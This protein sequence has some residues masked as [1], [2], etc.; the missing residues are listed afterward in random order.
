MADLLKRV[1]ME[2]VFLTEAFNKGLAD[3]TNGLKKSEDATKKTTDGIETISEASGGKLQTALSI[4]GK[5]FGVFAS[6]ALAAIGIVTGAIT[7]LIT[8][9]AALGLK[10]AAVENIETAFTA[11][12]GTAQVSL[13][14]LRTAVSGTI[15][16]DDLM[17]MAN[18]ALIG[19]SK[20]LAVAMGKN[21]PDALKIAGAASKAT[22][23]DLEDVFN[24]IELAIKRGS[25]RGLAQLGILVDQKATY[26][27]Y[28]K[29]IGVAADALTQ[30]QKSTA[31]MNAIMAAGQPLLDLY[32]GKQRSLGSYMKE[33]KANFENIADTIGSWF[34]PALKTVW[35]AITK[36]SGAFLEAVSAGGVLEP[37][38]TNLGAVMSFMADGFA[39]GVDLIMK[40]VGELTGKFKSN[41]DNLGNNALQWGIN[42]IVQLAKGIIQGATGALNAAAGFV[43]KLLTNWF[44]PGS[45]PKVAPQMDTWGADTMNVWL[46]GF[47]DAD[48]GLLN[49]LQGPIRSAMDLLASDPNLVGPAWANVSK[50][51]AEAIAGGDISQAF[52]DIAA[53]TGQYS[54]QIIKLAQDELKLKQ[55][56]DAMTASEER[57][58][59][60]KEANSQANATVNKGLQEYNR[61]LRS[62]AGKDQ[63]AAKL[64]EVNAAQKVADQSEKEI[65]AA[66]EAS[67]V[68]KE[69][70]E[71]M[72]KQVNLQKQM[73]DQI[74]Q[75]AQAQKQA[76]PAAAAGGGGGAGVGGEG[77]GGFNFGGGESP[78]EA[79]SNAIDKA[80]E[81]IKQKLAELWQSIKD[82][83]SEQLGP[84]LDGLSSAWQGLVDKATP[85]WNALKEGWTATFTWISDQ[86]AWAVNLWNEWWTK[87]GESVMTIVTPIWNFLTQGWSML[88]KIVGELFEIWL[89][90]TKARWEEVKTFLFQTWEGIKKII[91][92]AVGVIGRIVDGWAIIFKTNWAKV[93]ENIKTAV[94][95]K[96]ESIKASISNFLNQIIDQIM[97]V[98][99]RMLNTGRD[100][101]QGLW[102]GIKAKW[103]SVMG[104]IKEQINKI[105]EAIRKALGISSPSKVMMALGVQIPAG[106]AK[107]VE[108]GMPKVATAM[109]NVMKPVM[110]TSTVSTRTVN[111]T[112]NVD[113][114]GISVN[115]PITLAMLQNTMRTVLK[116]DL[117]VF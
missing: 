105:P 29:S 71:M 78:A 20:D 70:M 63:L 98:K 24:M 100:I 23:K 17:K 37:V 83:I 6:T 89:I 27:A 48:F 13:A 88:W 95:E 61:M 12:A 117:G 72:E 9:T 109:S 39:A 44:A 1:G 50:A 97:G 42:I 113:F 75:M 15:S 65:T 84:S 111:N 45:P 8:V 69:Q 43:S 58:K 26:E 18:E 35:G 103:D 102:D 68:A 85:I 40:A 30:E 11:L 57:L 28:A 108:G 64:A 3:Y 49:D 31:M 93:W 54:S 7:G 114:G 60:A 86:I 90:K 59:K 67:K 73:I 21:M 10:A 32:A 56:T 41:F 34:V 79:I 36:V 51:I 76:A 115:S 112:S 77:E 110:S 46:E 47:S 55:A 99:T 5:A 74:L 22:G 66:E 101:I 96:W 19:T 107:G 62:G 91:E 4:G 116:G 92:L 38:L 87:H 80:K 82:G 14:Q 52:D 81:Q 2:G 25:T 53:A 94:S 16:D 104:W 33:N 106:L